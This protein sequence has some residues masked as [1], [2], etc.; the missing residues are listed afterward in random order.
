MNFL[1]IHT[2]GDIADTSKSI[3]DSIKSFANSFNRIKNSLNG[4]TQVPTY[5]VSPM[6][7]LVAL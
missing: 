6:A 5:T 1:N 4:Y 3:W 2:A 7:G